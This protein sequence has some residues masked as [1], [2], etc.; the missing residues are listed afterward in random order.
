MDR[1]RLIPEAMK[2]G[3]D[4]QESFRPIIE[5]KK[6]QVQE[7]LRNLMILEESV[8]EQQE[9]DYFKKTK[10]NFEQQNNLLISEIIS[11]NNQF[12]TKQTEQK[13]KLFK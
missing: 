12:Q 11:N 2:H 7:K 9:I 4:V 3:H 6:K 5:D 1:A 8:K 10:H 13:I